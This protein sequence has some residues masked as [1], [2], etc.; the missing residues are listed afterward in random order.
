V[1]GAA[2]GGAAGAGAAVA[3]ANYEGCLRAGNN[4]VVTLGNALTLPIA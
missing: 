3:T 4:F 2:V 1:I